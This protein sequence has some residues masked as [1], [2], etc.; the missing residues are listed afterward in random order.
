MVC[1]IED[2]C[3]PVC[4]NVI[5]DPGGIALSSDWGDCYCHGEYEGHDSKSNKDKGGE[6]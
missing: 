2:D 6:I 1:F 3:Y 4:S 5:S